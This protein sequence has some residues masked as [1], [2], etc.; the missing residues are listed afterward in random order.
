MRTF[1]LSSAFAVLMAGPALAQA[2]FGNVGAPNPNE[3]AI[4]PQYESQNLGTL[5]T[6]C[7]INDVRAECQTAAVPDSGD[8]NSSSRS[9]GY[10]SDSTDFNK[11]YPGTPPSGSYQP[12]SG[13]RGTVS[14]G[15]LEAR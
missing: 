9:L 2:N 15:G 1:L 3:P 4:N 5:P 10:P 7:T 12:P 6:E 8:Q 13:S 11:G 14:G